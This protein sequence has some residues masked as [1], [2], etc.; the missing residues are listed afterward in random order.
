MTAA[1]VG[2]L[3]RVRTPR[4]YELV[5]EGRVD[6]VV[7]IGRQ[8]RFDPERVAAWIKRGGQQLPGGWRR[9]ERPST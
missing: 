3:L 1:E 9:E 2:S 7:R 6:G 8:L 5:R 4:V